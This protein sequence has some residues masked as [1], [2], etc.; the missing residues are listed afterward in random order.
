M[1]GGAPI[2]GGAF[3]MATFQTADGAVNVSVLKDHL[4]P[5]FCRMIGRPDW[6]DDAS[7]STGKAR[8]ARGDEIL[9]VASAAFAQKPAEHW[10]AQMREVGIL[11]ERVNTYDELFAH[12]QTQTMNVLTWSEQSVVGRV[13]HPNLPGPQPLEA[14][15]PR[16]NVPR[17][18]EH[19]R[20]ILAELGRDAQDVRRMLEQAIVFEPTASVA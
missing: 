9:R 20:E 10:C 7:L 15:S 19:T 4:W 3:P 13:P 16:T 18:G 1:T 2:A 11:N 5:P 6:A 17:I 8:R 14:D 12:E